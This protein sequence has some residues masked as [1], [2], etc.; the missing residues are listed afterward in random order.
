MKDILEGSTIHGL[1]HISKSK[2]IVARIAWLGVVVGCFS[3]AGYMIVSSFKQWQ[4]S[5]VSTTITTHPITDL[6]FPSVTVCPPRGSNTAISQALEKV[7]D[8]KFTESERN[9]LLAI[10]NNVFVET[11]NKNLAKQL[12]ELLSDENVR[13]ILKN[14]TSIPEIDDSSNMITIRSKESSGSFRTPKLVNSEKGE[15]YRKPRSFHLALDIGDT[16]G[17]GSLIVDVQSSGSW[18][19][20][21]EKVLKTKTRRVNMSDAEQFCVRYGGHLPSVES[22]EEHEYFKKVVPKFTPVWLGARRVNGSWQW[23]DGKLWN[24]SKKVAGP[25]NHCVMV[26]QSLCF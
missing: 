21:A 6:Q 13:S 8:V 2:S 16:V 7:N 10:A 4:E 23:M 14:Q 12:L 15:V 1:V 11:P 26:T 9:D 19:Y 25:G 3:V 22:E 17:D 20:T 5:P 24:S 18:F